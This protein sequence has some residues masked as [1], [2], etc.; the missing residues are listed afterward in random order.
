MKVKHIILAEDE[1]PIRTTLTL[2]LEKAGYKVTAVKNGNEALDLLVSSNLKSGPVDLLITDI[3]M[4]GITGMELIDQLNE[5]NINLPIMVITG[6]KSKEMVLQLMRK[7]CSNLI[8]KPFEPDEVLLRV[9]D[10][11]E[12]KGS[13]MT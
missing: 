8:E 7:G 10:V 5:N 2:V 12:R 11:I 6:F 1:K 9:R 4:P 3:R 13:T